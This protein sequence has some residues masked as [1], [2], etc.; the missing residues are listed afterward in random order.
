MS[1]YSENDAKAILQK[2]V[3]LSKADECTASLEGSVEG[4]VRYARNNVST[5]GV[6]S[7]AELEV[8]VAYGKRSGIATINEFDDASL[9]RV[10]ARAQ[11]LA[12]LAPENPEFMPAIE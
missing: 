1:I 9:A 4:N 10:V 7:D 12:K 11:E 3:A 5:S 8:K 2:V 6:V